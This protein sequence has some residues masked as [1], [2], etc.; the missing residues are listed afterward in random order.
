MVKAYE[1]KQE[2]FGV[3]IEEWKEGKLNFQDLVNRAYSYRL[4][5][6]PAS[7]IS[8]VPQMISFRIGD[9]LRCKCTSKEK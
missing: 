3:F 6:V 4:S 5:S 9:I 7:Y 2:E 8:L 1:Y